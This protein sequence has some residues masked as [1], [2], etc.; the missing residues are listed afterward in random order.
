M[1]YELYIIA[2]FSLGIEEL[3]PQTLQDL[4]SGHVFEAS[5]TCGLMGPETFESPIPG[6]GSLVCNNLSDSESHS[7]SSL[8]D[9]EDLSARTWWQS[10]ND[11]EDVSITL[12]L[13]GFFLLGGVQIDFRS[14][15][16][17]DVI[18]EVS[19]DF[20]ASFHPL[21]YY[22]NDCSG[23]FNLPDTPLN[24]INQLNANELICTSN[25]SSGSV[26]NSVSKKGPE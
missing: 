15:I 8:N 21:R 10:E 17:S 14:P 11:V 26:E 16:P 4:S 12:N 9:M 20:G 25:F 19:Q 5:S 23:K 18:I 1:S 24:Q 13:V 7:P 2:V 22:S 3:K 6:Q